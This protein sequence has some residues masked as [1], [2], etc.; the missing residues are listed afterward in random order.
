MNRKIKAAWVA[1]L[2]SNKFSQT[3]NTLYDRNSYCCLGVLC[4]IQDPKNL[5][6]WRYEGNP[7][8]SL[9]AG[10]TLE[11]INILVEAND[12]Q[13]WKFWQIAEFVDATL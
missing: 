12:A 7:P 2:K 11:D 9:R 1:A 8:R 3:T 6:P 10:L 5:C 4:Q 13:R